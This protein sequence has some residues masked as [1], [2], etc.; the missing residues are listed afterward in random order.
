MTRAPNLPDVF[1]RPKTACFSGRS[2][3][4]PLRSLRTAAIVAAAFV[5][6]PATTTR[7]QEPP[8][9]PAPAQPAWGTIDPLPAATG[10]TLFRVTNPPADGRLLVP[11][12][13]PQI[14]RAAL[15]TPDGPRD[16]PIEFSADA[17][18]VAILLPAAPTAAA[19]PAAAI[20]AIDTLDKTGQ[21]DDGRI[22]LAA[23]DAEVVGQTARLESHP[24]NHRI[25][26]WSDAADAVQWKLAATRWGM[27]DVRIAYS[28]AAPAGTE[29]A[30]DVGGTTLTG[31]LASTGS[32]YRYETLPLGRV[33]L[34]QA[35]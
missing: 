14:T 16:L 11:P 22:G 32:W 9:A 18:A 6:L 35:G 26:F 30:V 20:I 15:A 28:T 2:R 31:T 4:V 3:G 23:L 13:F 12:G 24:G 8:A 21:F 33:Y 19:A 27:Y 1:P 10:R 17:S 25:G 7:G 34:A 5:A 29:I